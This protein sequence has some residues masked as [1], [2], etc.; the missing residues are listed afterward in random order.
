M[1]VRGLFSSKPP[2]PCQTSTLPRIAVVGR[3]FSGMMMAIALMKAVKMPFHLQLFDPNSRV[4]GGQALAAGRSS[5][6]LNSRVRDLSVSSGDSD[7]FN[8]WLCSNADFRAAVPAAI[9]GFLQIFVPKSIFSDYVYQRFSDALSSRRD[10]VVQVSNENVL[11]VTR[12]RGTRFSVETS[13]G[14]HP[15]FD[16]V[17]L[18]TG[19]G[20]AEHAENDFDGGGGTPLVR[21][22]RLVSRPH[23]VL[24]GNGLRVVDRLLQ[25]RDAGYE[26][27]ITILSRHGLLPQSHTRHS[28]DP[29]FPP[30]PLPTTLADIVRYVRKACED[31]EEQG[32]SW[33]S[34]M[35][36]LRRHARSLWRA[37]PPA[38][39]QQFNRHLRA[40]YDSHRNRLPE[41]LHIRLTR[42]LAE[43]NSLMRKG[44]VTGRTSGGVVFKPAGQGVE[45]M[46][47]ADR[48]I[49][50][51][52]PAP[53]LAAPLL[54]DLIARRMVAVDELGL[55]LAVNAK[56]QPV[57]ENR[58]TDGIFTIGPLGLGSLP[59]IDLVP[60]IVAQTYAIAEML[61][62]KSYPRRRA[63]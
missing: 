29:V 55:G 21:A 49:D 14:A 20:L 18:A 62:S 43:G 63:V 51:E 17:I 16:T 41:A 33:Q 54:Q 12:N 3:G 25:L 40:F 44:L 10:I 37:L 2:M 35:N 57:V 11:A 27:Q 5:E 39:K 46:I 59:D 9:P 7:D 1:T 19:Y 47:Y 24:L 38:R 48:V 26:G 6:V 45:E 23:T 31:A 8:E 52:C 42:E 36:G 32:Q 34:V 58:T 61:L 60:E 15:P 30:E 56:G 13:G 28:A 4:S 22:R 53:D 50:C